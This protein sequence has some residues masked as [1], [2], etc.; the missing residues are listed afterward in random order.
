MYIGIKEKTRYVENKGI[1]KKFF[2]V[3]WQTKIPWIGIVLYLIANSAMIWLLLLVPRVNGNFYAG[4]VKV[5]TVLVVIGAD[6]ASLLVFSGVLLI[7]NIVSAKIDRNFRNSL[8]KKILSLEPKFF[9]QVSSNTLLSRITSDAESLKVFVVDIVLAE[10]I[11]L[12]T[13]IATITAMT[14]MNKNLAVIMAIMIPVILLI[15]FIMG[16]LNMRIGNLVKLKMSELTDYLSGQ[17]ARIKVIKS[18]N[19]VEN[20]TSRGE[21]LIGEYYKAEFKARL[22]DI[23]KAFIDTIVNIGPSVALIIIGIKLLDSHQLTVAGWVTFNA[24]ATSLLVFFREKSG[25]WVQIKLVQGQLNRILNL[26]YEPEEG[27]KPYLY[28][29]TKADDLIFDKVSFSYLDKEVLKGVSMIC[30]L[31]KLTAIVGP[32]GTGKTTIVKLLERIYEP[33]EGCIW[34][35]DQKISDCKLENWRNNIA[36]VSQNP[37]LISG[38]IRENILYGI[39]DSVSDE[40]IL[41]AARKLKAEKII[42]DRLGGLD[43]EVGQFGEKLSGGQRQKL[44]IVRAFL[45]NREYIILDEPTASL[46]MVAAYEVMD[47]IE[48]LRKWKTIIMVVHDIKLIQNADH[49]LVVEEKK[50]VIQGNFEEVLSKSEFFRAMA[51]EIK[52]DADETDK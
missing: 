18:Y 45:Q 43:S 22:I 17:L 2:R 9:D 44:S 46:D 15:A 26:Q 27:L 12:S 20:E 34:V 1:W 16:R 36:F 52:E 42:T 25:V 19:C 51:L 3:L 13:A 4:D 28:E 37:P 6:I 31:R 49:I 35:G 23:L 32:S 14:S 10:L 39:Q 40:E 30:P 7:K 41:V 29:K 50:G 11:S 48:E 47:A 5:S 8:W 33:S 24:Y 38:T 21:Y